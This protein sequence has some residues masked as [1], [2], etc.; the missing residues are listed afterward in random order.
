[1]QDRRIC[2]PAPMPA[3]AA[4]THLHSMAASD[5]RL[6]R[7]PYLTENCCSEMPPVRRCVNRLQAAVLARRRRSLPRRDTDHG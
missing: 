2:L 1:M 3:A 7:Q 4:P 6:G 5:F